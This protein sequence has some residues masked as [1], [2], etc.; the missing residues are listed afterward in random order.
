MFSAFTSSFEKL[1]LSPL[2][3]SKQDILTPLQLYKSAG[4]THTIFGT[5]IL[6]LFLIQPFLGLA[7]H[8]FYKK[9]AARSSVSHVHIWFG[10][11]III[12]AVINGGLGLKLAANTRACEIA[13]GVVAGVVAVVYAATVLLKRRSSQGVGSALGHR[14]KD[15]VELRSRGASS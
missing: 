13:Y 2:S 14:E 1:P 5:V 12:L 15:A 3:R 7:H 9:N 4:R 10:R 6:V 11:V 8:H